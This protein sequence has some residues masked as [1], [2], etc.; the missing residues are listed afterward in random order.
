MAMS[1]GKDL[2]GVLKCLLQARD[3]F[4]CTL[5][6]PVEEMPWVR[7]EEP[8]VLVKEAEASCPELARA[9]AKPDLVSALAAATAFSDQ[10]V[11]CGSLYFVADFTRLVQRSRT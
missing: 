2:R 1:A 7:P 8:A 6:S 5:F 4:V 10:L 9:V 11:L 3:F